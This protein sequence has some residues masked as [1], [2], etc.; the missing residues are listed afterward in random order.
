MDEINDRGTAAGTETRQRSSPYPRD[1][2]KQAEQLAKVVFE[3]GPRHVDQEALA[4]ALGFTAVRNGAYKRIRASANYF[5]VVEYAGDDWISVAEPWIA[6]FHNEDAE[7]LA[8]ARRAAV[9]T[10]ALYKQLFAEYGDRMLPKLDRLARE[11]YLN[12]AY[13]ILKDAAEGAALTFLESVDYAGLVDS[14]GFLRMES[15]ALD[16]PSRDSG[17]FE[18]AERSSP[19]TATPPLSSADVGQDAD[20]LE[21]RLRDGRKVLILIPAPGSLSADDKARLKG[22]IDLVLEP[23]GI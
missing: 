9:V 15:A 12:P 20:R 13:G 21:V 10:P 11:L 5:G 8:A 6:V 14:K 2:L 17:F 1:G 22:H 19:T 7:E 16:S 4:H 18:G 3:L 23:N